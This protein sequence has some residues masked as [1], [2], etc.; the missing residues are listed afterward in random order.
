MPPDVF[1]SHSSQDAA[2][3]ARVCAGLESRGLTCWI[4][5]RDIRSGSSWGASIVKALDTCPVVV[6]ILTEHANRSRQ[7]AREVERADGKGA[8][9]INF[10]V[11]SPTLSPA[12]EYFLSADH[13]FDATS[14]PAEAHLPALADAVRALIDPAAADAAVAAPRRHGSGTRPP[15]T[16]EH[17]LVRSLDEL[18]PD[19]W[20]RL[21]GGRLSQFFKTLFADR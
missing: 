2:L 1:I 9:V 6:L 10:R 7:V 20:N 17:E 18:A 14:G 13:W 4:A 12:L 15:P 19:D 5:P 21:P 16:S 11:E 3:A 8:R